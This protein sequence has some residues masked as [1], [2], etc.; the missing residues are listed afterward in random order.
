[1]LR[2]FIIIIIIFLIFS[3]SLLLF[4]SKFCIDKK[5][6]TSKIIYNTEI[7]KL[8][9]P[10]IDTESSILITAVG[11]CTL[12]SHRGNNFVNSFPYVLEQNN[13][14]YSYFF[15]GVYGI[16]STDDLTIANLETTFT[17]AT[18]PA[19][20]KFTFKG[21]SEYAKILTLGSVEVVNVANNHTYDYLDEGFIDTAQALNNENI[22]YFGNNEYKI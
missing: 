12:G 1:M 22:P 18:T 2:K 10:T 17:D 11:D 5:T 8:V 21:P 9:E 3:L 19:I 7:D 20:K 15:K 14:D 16:T 4:L 6:P 13:N